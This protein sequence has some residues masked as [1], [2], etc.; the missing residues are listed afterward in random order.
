MEHSNVKRVLGI[1]GSPRSGGNT[2]TL[3]DEILSA[4]RKEGAIVEKIMLNELEIAPCQACN[5]C[6]TTGECMQQD[7]MNSLWDKLRVS[8]VWVLGTPVYWWGPS[9]QLKAFV[10]R[11]YAKAVEPAQKEMFEGRRV[12]LAIPLGDTDP[13]TARHTAGMFEDALSYIN[14]D[15]FA[16]VLAPGAYDRGDVRGQSEVLKE[17]R[18]VGREAV[19]D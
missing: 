3:V 14:A 5:A 2:D 11:W 4:A 1:V 12:I 8:D 13:R 18:R 10:D 9:A 6:R 17:A 15:L 19:T 16:T 7:D